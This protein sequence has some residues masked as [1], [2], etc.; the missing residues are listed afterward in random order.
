M[1]TKTKL[2]V[3]DR[4]A[5]ER[6]IELA[7]AESAAQRQQIE[8]M[9]ATRG[10]ER[11][12]RFAAYCCQDAALNLRP[13]QTP[14]CWILG[15]PDRLLAAQTADP[16]HRRAAVLCRKL[17]DLGLS[18]YEPDP[19]D[20]IA[21]RERALETATNAAVERGPATPDPDT[22]SAAPSTST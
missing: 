4:E 14:P 19:I 5:L 3:V 22:G 9:L 11:T 10:W 15:D 1:R 17:L 16:D 2:S 20:A 18:R 12:A 8:D 6:A 13:W 21:H 7:R